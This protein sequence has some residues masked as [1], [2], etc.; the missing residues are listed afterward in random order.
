ML[1]V[2][3]A[4]VR[5]RNRFLLDYGRVWRHRGIRFSYVVGDVKFTEGIR[6]LRF[7]GGNAFWDLD[8]KKHCR[9]VSHV[10]PSGGEET[11]LVCSTCGQHRQHHCQPR[12]PA[13]V[14]FRIGAHIAVT[15]D[16]IPGPENEIFPGFVVRTAGRVVRAQF[17]SED[18]ATDIIHF[19]LSPDGSWSDLD[20]AVPCRIALVE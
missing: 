2:S 6:R 19:H 5:L 20:Y 12:G 14:P 8:D 16:V 1:E 17:D 10:D 9:L 15:Y 4:T 3:A 18:G 11:A 13:L 7:R